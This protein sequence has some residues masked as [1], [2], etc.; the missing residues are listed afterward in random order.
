M[1]LRERQFVTDRF[2]LPMLLLA[3]LVFVAVAAIFARIRGLTSI[4]GMGI[5]VGVLGWY[6]VPQILSGT[7]PLT[8]CLAGAAMIA[9][10]SL[11]LAHGFNKQT[12]DAVCG[13]M[14]ALAMSAFLAVIFVSGAPLTSS[15]KCTP[16]ALVSVM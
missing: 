15:G 6:I 2:R 12:T 11:Y 3:I 5:S 14:V 7:D 9:V 4:V 8:V 1:A 13:T 10:I 16:F